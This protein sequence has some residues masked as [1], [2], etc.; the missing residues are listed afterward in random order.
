VLAACPKSEDGA[1]DTDVQSLGKPT[2]RAHAAIPQ[3]MMLM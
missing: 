1:C 3:S 2:E